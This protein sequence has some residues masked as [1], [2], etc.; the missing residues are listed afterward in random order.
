MYF[1]SVD[2]LPNNVYNVFPYWPKWKQPCQVCFS[3]SGRFCIFFTSMPPEVFLMHI[4]VLA[5]NYLDW[6]TTGHTFG[7]PKDKWWSWSERMM[8]LSS[9]YNSILCFPKAKKRDLAQE[10]RVGVW[11]CKKA[12]N[13]LCI[14]VLPRGSTELNITGISFPSFQF[15]PLSPPSSLFL[16]LPP[17]PLP[18]PAPSFLSFSPSSLSSLRPLCWVMCH[19]VVSGLLIWV[20]ECV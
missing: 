16:L 2:E 6:V 10:C 14:P 20:C 7:R 5:K 18:L 1:I 3:C 9:A 4:Y 11:G 17:S 12:L 15:S 13:S 19:A 8:Q